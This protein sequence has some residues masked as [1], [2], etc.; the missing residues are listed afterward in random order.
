[1]VK[2]IYLVTLF[3][4]TF[5]SNFALS[6]SLINDN[7]Q[8][9]SNITENIN[10][11]DAAINNKPIIK[12]TVQTSLKPIDKPDIPALSIP[13]APPLQPAL[14]QPVMHQGVEIA[15]KKAADDKDK[16]LRDKQKEMA[17]KQ[18]EQ[19]VD[20]LMDLNYSTK[21]PPKQLY[22]GNLQPDNKHIPP[23]Y[24][25]SYYLF[26]A[27]RAIENNDIG[28]L[29]AVLTRFDFING[30]NKD[31]DTLLIH[32]TETDSLNAARVILA[33]GGYVNGVNNRGRT[34]LHYAATTGNVEMIK[35]LLTMGADKAI[36]DD[37]GM[38]AIDYAR[39]NNNQDAVTMMNKY[40]NN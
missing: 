3:L 24:F 32:A 34:A 21:I 9:K 35:L 36:A 10:Y 2:K 13:A 18:Q 27:F 31:G 16:L 7:D 17:A 39:A 5:G 20:K 26:L 40:E 15:A 1:M 29:R 19:L 11:V 6:S 25:K 33:K 8:N 37:K 4:V 12:S 23:V 28:D 38:T 22:E 14:P 30:Q